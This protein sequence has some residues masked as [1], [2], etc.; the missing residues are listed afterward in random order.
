[1]I[2]LLSL[3][4]LVTQPAAQPNCE[5][6]PTKRDI[7]ICRYLKRMEELEV[8]TVDK[9]AFGTNDEMF[10]LRPAA[11]KCKL[12]NHVDPIDTERSFFRIINA[13]VESKKC[14]LK[15]IRINTPKLEWTEQKEKELEDFV[16]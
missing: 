3:A 14:L 11:R 7:E 5:S 12:I 10:S 4:L 6:P 9:V 8:K 2:L 1:M 13:T 15:W 16:Q